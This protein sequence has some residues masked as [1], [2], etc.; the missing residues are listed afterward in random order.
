MNGASTNPDAHVLAYAA[1][2][3]K[4]GL[5]VTKKL[6]G[7][8]FVFWGG[9]EGYHTL[10]N[11]DIGRELDHM[12]N[13]FKMV[14][15][16]K[17]KIGFTGQLLI[18]PK[19]K[20]PSKHQYDYD[21]QTVMSFLFKYGLQND[22]KLNI[23][24][25]HTTLAGHCHEHDIVVASANKLL[26]SVDSNTGSPDLGWDTDQFPMDVKNTTAI[27]KVVID[28]GGL[29]PGGLNFDC[30]VRRESIDLTDMFVSHIGAMDAF[31]RGLRNATRMIDEGHLSTLVKERYS[32]FDSGL[33]ARIE[34]GTASLEECEDFIHSK[35]EP[36]LLSGRQ[37]HCEAVVNYYV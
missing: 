30:K 32:S 35:G 11:T 24:P 34:A 21:A 23:E 3:V 6:G 36:T 10:L 20:E 22:F 33:G 17:N 26:G 37:E 28:Q 8:N 5:E 1:A 14:I 18:E 9:R 2:Q 27:M 13:F 4:K 19:P 12:A 15:E 25:N 16:Y 7:V 29:T 31:A